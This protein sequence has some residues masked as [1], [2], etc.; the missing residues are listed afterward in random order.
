MIQF[1]WLKYTITSLNN[2][3]H[4]QK[5]TSL[6]FHLSEALKVFSDQQQSLPPIE[7]VADFSISKI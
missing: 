2:C 4:L 7:Q 1:Q 6:H 5:I 3:K